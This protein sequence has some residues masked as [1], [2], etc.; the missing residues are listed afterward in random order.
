MHCMAA[1]GVCLLSYLQRTYQDDSLAQ[2]QTLPLLQH[3][4]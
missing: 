1:D 2:E 4:W 3:G